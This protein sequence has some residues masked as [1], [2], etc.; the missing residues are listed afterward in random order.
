M[1]EYTELEYL[2]VND[3]VEHMLEEDEFDN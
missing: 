2:D 3:F 1:E